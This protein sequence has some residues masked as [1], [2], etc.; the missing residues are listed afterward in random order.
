[1]QRVLNPADSRCCP[2]CASAATFEF[3]GRSGVPVHQNLLV[4]DPA[5]ART[6]PRGMLALRLCRS[7]GFAFNAAFDGDLLDYGSA[8]DNTQ[9]CSESFSTYVDELVREL[10]EDRGVRGCRV[11]EVGCGKGGFLKRLIAYKGAGNTGLGFDP[12]YLGPETAVQG[13]VRFVRR[14]Y[15]REAAQY[16]ADVVV[17]RHVI[18]HIPD[19]LPLLRAVRSALGRS[20]GAR[21]FFET[22]CLDWILSHQ[23][24]WDFFYEHCSLFTPASLTTAFRRAGF[25]VKSVRHIFGGQY[26]WL[27]AG[28]AA[29]TR[30]MPVPPGRTPELARALACQ[31]PAMVASWRTRLREQRGTGPVA[32]WGAGAKGATFCNL[33]D[34]DCSEIACV[35]DVNP[36]KQGKYVA[37]TGHRIVA[38]E[39]ASALDA[40]TVLVL[41]PNYTKEIADRL[42]RRH[43]RA[44]VVDLMRAG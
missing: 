18:E 44:H 43:S 17:C 41:N 12:T 4:A 38:T 27:E 26:L 19:P 30:E 24:M 36:A 15:D 40:A 37:G 14:F 20:P 25:A 6:M 22:P 16:P 21:V 5:A 11:L 7:C 29:E 13:R 31:E 23:V 33:A 10:V 34:P 39:D 2:V 32:V 8:Y 35:I 9:T 42:A 3:L 1:M 28:I